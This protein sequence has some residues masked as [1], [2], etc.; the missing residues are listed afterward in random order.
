MSITSSSVTTTGGNVYTSSGNTVITWLSICNTT[1]GNLTANV[2]VLPSGASANVT[3]TIISNVLITGGDTLQVYMGNEKLL[4][5]NG[6]AIYSIA[7]ANSLSAVISYT[8]S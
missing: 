1:A 7:N 6:G 4:L 3:N 5:D 2:H 8:S